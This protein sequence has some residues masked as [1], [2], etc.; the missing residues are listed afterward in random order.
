MGEL[1]TFSA[2]LSGPPEKVEPFSSLVVGGLLCVSLYIKHLGLEII[3]PCFGLLES[4]CQPS[5][6]IV[7]EWICNSDSTE[8]LGADILHLLP[9][10][11]P[12]DSLSGGYP[13]LWVR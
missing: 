1:S 3:R 5:D 13:V 4:G 10:D 9:G 12:T 6:L 2:S 8:G 11:S 7:H